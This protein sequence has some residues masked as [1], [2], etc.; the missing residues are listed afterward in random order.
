MTLRDGAELVL[1][2]AIW[3]AS[4]L[5]MRI[6]APVIGPLATADLRMLIGGLFLGAVFLVL[7]LHPGLKK[8]FRIFLVIGLVN[9][10]LPF[11]LYSLAALVLPASVE[12]VLNAL[13]PAFGAL[14]GALFLGESFTL[15]KA[16]GLALGFAGVVVVAGGLDL[17][18][19]AWGSAALGACILA[20]A[21][22][23]AGGVLVKRLAAAIP[24]AHL[25]FGSQLLAGLALLPL[26]AIAAPVSPPSST[27]L[28]LLIVFGVL[29]SGLAYLLYYGL[30]KRIGPTRTLT[31]TF[32]MPVFGILWGALLLNEPVTPALIG[33]ACAVLVGTWLVTSR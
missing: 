2:A 29:C 27:T 11:L 18:T 25:A 13:S 12:V 14:A 3:G 19:S 8:N 30:M 33:G 15:K 22:Y 24:P 5:F 17:G 20:P 7:K 21:S 16:G 4:F 9:S 32:L 23:A 6:L 26:L 28:G 31:V 1:L 10:A